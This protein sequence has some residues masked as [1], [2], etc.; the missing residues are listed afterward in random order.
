MGIPEWAELALSR[1]VPVDSKWQDRTCYVSE[2]KIHEIVS[3]RWRRR[4]IELNS[5]CRAMDQLPETARSAVLECAVSVGMDQRA[6]EIRR[7]KRNLESTN[8]KLI[9]TL[10]LAAQLFRERDSQIEK[11][12][13]SDGMSNLFDSL[14]MAIE[15]HPSW[16]FVAARETEAFLQRRGQSRDGP[17]MADLLEAFV[18]DSS[19]SASSSFDNVIDASQKSHADHIRLMVSKIAELREGWIPGIGAG[20]RLTNAALADLIN[21]AF[22]L[23]EGM[24]DE[25]TVKKRLY[26]ASCKGYDYW[27]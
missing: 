17:D 18:D 13:L 24:V 23:P 25:G 8:Q 7:Q 16:A 26:D 19:I 15:C 14:A 11:G 9:Q 21:V 10:Q 5:F 12:N 27:S 6:L 2:L 4:W 22:D 20:F 1:L 3:N